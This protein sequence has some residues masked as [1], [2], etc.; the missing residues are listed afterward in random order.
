MRCVYDIAPWPARWSLIVLVVLALGAGCGGGGGG[1]DFSLADASEAVDSAVLDAAEPPEVIIVN[2]PDVLADGT[3]PGPTDLEQYASVFAPDRVLQI[4]LTIA[5]EDWDALRGETRSLLDVFGPGCLDAPHASPFGWYGAQ[6]VIDGEEVGRIGVR[7]KGFLGSLSDTKPSLKLDLDRVVAGQTYRALERMTLNNGRQDPSLVHQC[8][9]Y[10]LFRRAGQPA[11]RCNLAHVTVNGE[12]LGVYVHVQDVRKQLLREYFADDEGALY[13]GTLSDLRSG[14]LG[15]FSRK[16]NEEITDRSDLER[17]AHVIETASD[18]EL[19]D[20][21]ETVF[22]L[23]AFF[24]H[25]ALEVLIAHW[26]GFAGNTNNYFL[27][28]NPDDGGRFV[29]LPWGIDAILTPWALSPGQSVDSKETLVANSLLTWRL[30]RHPEGRARYEARLRE[31]LESTWDEAW[32]H[33]ELDRLEQQVLEH[34]DPALHPAILA[35]TAS[36]RTFIDGRRAAILSELE[37]GLPQWDGNLRSDDVC[38]KERGQLDWSFETTYGTFEDP[39]IFATGTGTSH[40]L[41]FDDHDFPVQ[42]FGARAGAAPEPEKMGLESF[43][44]AAVLNPDLVI[45]VAFDLPSRALVPGNMLDLDE[46]EALVA[47][48]VP[49]TGEVALVGFLLDGALTLEQAGTTQGAPLV[50]RIAGGVFSL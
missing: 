36:L 2:P 22:D 18:A 33:A 9:G 46:L 44:L 47:A 39:D 31:L 26:D 8:L 23:D 37:G 19:I 30:A 50:G 11:S 7:K 32:L 6:L 21:L 15:T 1:E 10:A 42:Y 14:W 25:W 43:M 28:A 12:P 49:S 5:P 38:A 41:R 13:E 4:E 16:T 29:F 17:A 34:S 27:Y 24:T 35:R 40:T 45:L 20:A 48:Y 3:P